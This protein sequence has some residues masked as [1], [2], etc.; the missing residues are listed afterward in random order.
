VELLIISRNDQLA[1]YKHPGPDKCM[2][3]MRNKQALEQLRGSQPPSWK[4]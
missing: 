4:R 3:N 2:D 1:A